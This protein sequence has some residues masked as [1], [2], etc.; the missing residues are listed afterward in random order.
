M[1]GWFELNKNAKGEFHFS[2]KSGNAETI[3]TSE[4][5]TS[6]ASA[7]NGIE[8]VKTN[9]A[10]EDRFER[11]TASDGRFYFLLKAANHQVIGNSQMYGTEGARDK[12]IAAVRTAGPSATTKDKTQ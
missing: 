11:K 10:N 8:S 4:T 2:L 12:G 3:L 9:S 1:A 7:E 5:Y 6:K